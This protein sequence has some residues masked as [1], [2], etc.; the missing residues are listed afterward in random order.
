MTKLQKTCGNFVYYV[1][2]VLNQKRKIFWPQ[3][4]CP[5]NRKKRLFGIAKFH[6]IDKRACSYFKQFDPT[7]VDEWHSE[8]STSPQ[9]KGG[10]TTGRLAD[11]RTERVNG[12]VITMCVGRITGRE[13]KEWRPREYVH[14]RMSVHEKPSGLRRNKMGKI[15][16]TL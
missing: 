13:G 10:R 2:K 6:S 1:P 9:K 14:T 4:L 8:T 7:F 16:F 11:E 5:Q 15:H 3:R 12:D